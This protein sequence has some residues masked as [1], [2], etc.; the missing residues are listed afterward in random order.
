MNA[1]GF[2]GADEHW[3]MEFQWRMWGISQLAMLPPN[4][5]GGDRIGARLRSILTRQDACLVVP[6]TPYDGDPSYHATKKRA[7]KHFRPIKLSSF[8]DSDTVKD[9]QLLEMLYCKVAASHQADCIGSATGARVPEADQ[10]KERLIFFPDVIAW[11]NHSKLRCKVHH[12]VVLYCVSDAS[13]I[14]P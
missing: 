12:L 6:S 13:L 8:K 14:L 5:G 3:H 4:G 7:S 1:G 9:N 2:D 10:S 11:Y